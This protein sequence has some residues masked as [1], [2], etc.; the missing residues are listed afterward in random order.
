[1]LVFRAN[2]GTKIICVK[3]AQI[4]SRT[5]P[6]AFMRKARLSF[7]GERHGG[8]EFLANVNPVLQHSSVQHKVLVSAQMGH[9]PRSHPQREVIPG[10]HAAGVVNPY[11]LVGCRKLQSGLCLW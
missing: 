2:P 5:A 3:L 6:K 10:H 7:Q 8:Y 11:L 1:M 4:S 9:I